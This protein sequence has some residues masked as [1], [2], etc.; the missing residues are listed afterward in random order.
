MN[1]NYICQKCNGA[2]NVDNKIVFS[3]KKE[4]GNN[5]LIFLSPE[6]G[7]YSY[8]TSNLFKLK[9]GEKLDI[10]CPICHQNLTATDIHENLAKI[11]MIDEDGVDYDIFFSEIVGERCTFKVKGRNVQQFG[12]KFNQYMNFFGNNGSDNERF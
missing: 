6:V 4:N 8:A 1:N 5:G 2:L 7:N 10:F 9:D 3:V 12:D 11:T